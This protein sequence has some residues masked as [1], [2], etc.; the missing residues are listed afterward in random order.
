MTALLT[1][2][3]LELG[4]PV[5]AQYCSAPRLRRPRRRSVAGNTT[6]IGC[7]L[8]CLVEFRKQAG[9]EHA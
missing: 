5:A 3:G 1:L 2:T 6:P 4:T 7:L 8:L 9:V